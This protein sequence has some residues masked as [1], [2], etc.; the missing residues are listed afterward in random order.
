M[1]RGG[2][3][4]DDETFA[5]LEAAVI[6][7]VQILQGKTKSG[8]V[9][10]VGVP[11]EALT[12]ER[13]KAIRKKYNM[14]QSQF[15]QIMHISGSTIKNWEQGRRVPEDPARV[16]FMIADKD[17]NPIIATMSVLKPA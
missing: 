2:L 15:A 12:P 10:K 17:I 11:V 14:S 9:I 1:D 8:R 7:G 6:E 3:I 4:I 5:L 16:L 13:I